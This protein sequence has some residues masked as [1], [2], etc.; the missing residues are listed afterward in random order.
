VWLP[1]YPLVPY[2]LP[3][4]LPTSRI[5]SGCLPLNKIHLLFWG[6]FL[7]CYYL[8]CKFLKF[9]R[10]QLSCS[11]SSSNFSNTMY[12]IWPGEIL[13]GSTTIYPAHNLYSIYSSQSISSQ[14]L[15][16]FCDTTESPLPK[17][18]IGNVIFPLTWFHTE[19]PS[20]QFGDLHLGCW[21]LGPSN[22]YWHL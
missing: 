8:Q 19:E 6:V 4:S 21:L 7:T 15:P 12:T 11:D 5:I 1:L 10:L 20:C 9:H 17:L 14:A 18:W 2:T 16:S 3:L 22:I 13:P